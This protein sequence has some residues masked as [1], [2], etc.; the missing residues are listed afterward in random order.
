MRKGID[1]SS[2][3]AQ[4]PYGLGENVVSICVEMKFRILC[5][6]RVGGSVRTSYRGVP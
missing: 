1:W 6:P 4:H 2:Y 3:E 5:N